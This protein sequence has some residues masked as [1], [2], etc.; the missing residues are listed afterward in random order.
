MWIFQKS[1][2]FY[3]QMTF[4]RAPK[5]KKVHQKNRPFFLLKTSRRLI[6][7]SFQ[8]TDEALKGRGKAPDGAKRG[9][10]R[11]P[12]KIRFSSEMFHMGH[13]ASFLHRHNNIPES[14]SK[15]DVFNPPNLSCSRNP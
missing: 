5:R 2:G 9:S 3:G 12:L 1:S 15:C 8:Q 4:I 11:T 10:V 14:I 6:D 7:S 13:F